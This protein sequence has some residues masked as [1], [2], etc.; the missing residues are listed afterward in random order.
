MTPEIIEMLESAEHP[1][2]IQELLEEVV[3]AVNSSRTFI[4]SNFTQWD[5]Y[6]ATY[7]RK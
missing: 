3:G 5:K 4:A 2:N 1:D 6:L 7:K